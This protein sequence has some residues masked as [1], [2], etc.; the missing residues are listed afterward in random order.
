MDIRNRTTEINE[1]IL[2]IRSIKDQI[3]T[4]TGL[5]KESGFKDEN[6]T[7]G[8]S[9]WYYVAAFDNAGTDAVHGT[10][11]SLESY[12]TMCYGGNS[13]WGTESGTVPAFDYWGKYSSANV[14]AGEVF[15]APNPWK[16][17]I[18]SDI[19]GAGGAQG[20]FVR[21]INTNSQ[22]IKVFDAA[23]TLVWESEGDTEGDRESDRGN[24][25]KQV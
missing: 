9:Y 25:C 5:M 2:T 12:S 21:F 24:S 7:F 11:P 10:V 22:P 19:F 3:N 14:A 4:L 16:A 18:S 1:K 8:M 17:S 15:V 23:G 6:V 13:A 20:Y